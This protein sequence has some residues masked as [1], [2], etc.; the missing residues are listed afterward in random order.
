M[1]KDCRK[2]NY[3][4]FCTALILQARW[5]GGRGKFDSFLLI[6]VLHQSSCFY[7]NYLCF[8]SATYISV[9]SSGIFSHKSRSA[10]SHVAHCWCHTWAGEYGEQSNTCLQ[11][12]QV[13]HTALPGSLRG[14]Q[15]CPR[16]TWM[17]SALSD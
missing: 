3:Y 2:N 13:Q 7:L 11:P 14:L 12:W 8:S 15:P 9:I 10:G 5:K 6:L 4:W 1:Y 17:Q 16:W